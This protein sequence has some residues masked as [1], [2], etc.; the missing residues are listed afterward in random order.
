MAGRVFVY[1]LDGVPLW[2]LKI[3]A[4][5]GYI[6]T[7]SQLMESGVYGVLNAIPP[8]ETPPNW[9]S[10][11]TG[12]DPGTH[13]IIGF[14]TIDNQY[15]FRYYSAR[16][17]KVDPVWI[18][19]SRYGKKSIVV[20]VPL[21]YPPDKINGFMV[22]D[23]ERYGAPMK[24]HVYPEYI[25]DIVKKAKNLVDIYMENTPEKALEKLYENIVR[26]GEAVRKL[27]ERLDWDLV[28]VVYREPDYVMHKFLGL[29]KIPGGDLEA[30]RKYSKVP[31]KVLSLLN[32]ELNKYMEL[33]D[34]NDHIIIMSDHGHMPRKYK[35][36][37]NLFLQNNAGMVRLKYGN[38][39]GRIIKTGTFRKYNLIKKIWY[40]TPYGVRLKIKQ[41]L[42]KIAEFD[43][44]VNPE[45]IDWDKTIAVCYK[46]VG[47]VKINL[48]GRDEKGIVPVEDYNEVVNRIKRIFMEENKR[49]IRNGES[50]L[51]RNVYSI[52]ELYKEY[53]DPWYPD[54]IIVPHNNI[55]IDIRFNGNNILR[56]METN[57]SENRSLTY[58]ENISE[59]AP[60]GMYVFHG[61]AFKNMGLG[62]S[63]NMMD[64]APYILYLLNVPIPS[65]IRGKVNKEIIDSKW[66][67]SNPLKVVSSRKYEVKLRIK[68]I[69]KKLNK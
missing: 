48:M 1:G 36:S 62:P 60:E 20:N 43:K 40:R 67:A 41:I 3:A 12:V 53:D 15:K 59:H 26:R 38:H 13:G 33:L 31:H 8:I 63:L 24:E 45:T 21:T 64:I 61:P 10:A 32:D 25:Y 34:P 16:D 23:D 7:I 11:F 17:R 35:F 2:F 27:M 65:Y 46:K 19:L 68:A 50:P 6:S 49:R 47:T 57:I 55:A 52:R 69:R 28:I 29:E 9:Y 44:G 18:I 39:R 66:I 56:R 4:K 54:L 42:L 37:I 14:F 30:K 22:G 51:I 58:V 5:E